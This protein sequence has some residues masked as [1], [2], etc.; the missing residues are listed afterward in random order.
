MTKRID[1][2]YQ[3]DIELA[4]LERDMNEASK[5]PSKIDNRAMAGLQFAYAKRC[6]ELARELY[7]SVKDDESN[8]EALKNAQLRA[9]HAVIYYQSALGF[10]RDA[11]KEKKKQRGKNNDA[12]LNEQK[13]ALSHMGLKPSR[14]MLGYSWVLS[15]DLHGAQGL[16]S[17]RRG[18][19]KMSFDVE[20]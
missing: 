19:E 4:Q 11:K 12:V 2:D 18:M 13:S 14:T 8:D 17:T 5:N 16:S 15:F 1:F 6:D 3:S 9:A 10:F 20:L 7:A